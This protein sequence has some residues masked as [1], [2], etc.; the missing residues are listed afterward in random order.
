MKRKLLLLTICGLLALC[1]TNG[2]LAEENDQCASEC[3]GGKT[4]VGFADGDRATCLCV[5]P[6]EG[7][8]ATVEQPADNPDPSY[9]AGSAD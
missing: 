9:E 6:G 5:E 1:F 4:K 7:M 2:A 8:E 3:D